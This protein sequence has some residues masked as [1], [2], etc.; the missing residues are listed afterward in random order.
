MRLD[1][2]EAAG[3]LKKEIFI[4]N[5]VLN[6]DREIC[7]F[8]CGHPVL[9]H[10]QGVDLSERIH[11]VSIPAPADV[12]LVGSSPM[13]S[14]FRQSMK[15]IGNTLFSVKP[16][17]HILGFLRCEQGVGDV[18]LPPK[19]LPHSILRML[20]KL[21]GPSRIMGFVDRVKKRAGVEEKFLA[22]FS[23][24]VCRRNPMHAYSE[25]L[26]EGVG[27]KTGLFVQYR[28][29]STMIDRVERRAPRSAKVWF[30][31]YGGLTYPILGS[32]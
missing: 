16:G 22:H 12:V 14:D 4:V 28:D 6:H 26:P 11:G 10:R 18:D 17:G 15:C 19:A 30:F 8:F 31:P 23:L 21:M 2:E 3:M 9:A 24:Q 29:V 20:L 27:K 5:A 7:E 1:L 32:A 25:N 13:D